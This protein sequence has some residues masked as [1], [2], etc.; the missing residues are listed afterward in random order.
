MDSKNLYSAI[1]STK[2]VTQ[3]QL[4]ID[5]ASIKEMLV[6]EKSVQI[7]WIPASEQLANCLT[8]R[9]ASCHQLMNILNTGYFAQNI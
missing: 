7:N 2:F 6:K 1:N 3:K 4:R 9:G 8:K 5:V